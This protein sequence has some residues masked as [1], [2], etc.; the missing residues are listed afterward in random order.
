MRPICSGEAPGQLCWAEDG[1]GDWVL[2]G[3]G[4]GERGFLGRDGRQGSGPPLRKAHICIQRIFRGF[5]GWLSLDAGLLIALG[6][7]ENS[8]LE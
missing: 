4:P 6:C 8:F 7:I 5:Q 3:D 1:A 2:W